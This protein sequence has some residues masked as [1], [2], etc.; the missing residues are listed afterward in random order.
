MTTRRLTIGT[1]AAVALVTA[2]LWTNLVVDSD[3]AAFLPSGGGDRQMMLLNQLRDGIA[4]RLVLIEIRGGAADAL[5]ATSHRVTRSLRASPEFDYASNGGFDVLES[6]LEALMR[7][8]Y[9]LSPGVTEDAFSE[10]SL[11][12]AMI[13]RLDA[14]GTTAGAL[15]KRF[16]TRDPTG[17]TM[18]LVAKAA[19]SSR[20]RNDSGAWFDAQGAAAVIVAQTRAAGSD[21]SGQRS[22][23][24]A[25]DAI[26]RDASV[27]PQTVR[28]SSPGVLAVTSQRI[29]E[30]SATRLSVL[31]TAAILLVLVA[32]Y[33]S[34]RL[35]VLCVLPAVVGLLVAVALVN[36]L[37]GSVHAIT[38]AFG[39]TLLGEAVDYPSYLLTASPDSASASAAP[40]GVGRMFALAVATT[41]CGAISLLFS[42]FDGLVQLGIVTVVGVVV[43]GVLTWYVLPEW[44][45]A[46]RSGP[47]FSKGMQPSWPTWRAMY[48][49]G[50]FAVL[51]AALIVSGRGAT[52]WDDDPAR[53]SPL[54]TEALNRDRDLRSALGAPDARY[55]I[56]VRGDTIDGALR[57]VES[58]GPT[59]DDAVAGGALEDYFLA[60]DALPSKSTQRRRQ[61]ALPTTA[62]LRER[63]AAATRGLPLRAAAFEPFVQDVAQ[64]KASEPMTLATLARTGLGLRADSLVGTDGRGAWIWVPLTLVHRPETLDRIVRAAGDHVSLID[65]RGEAGALIEAFRQRALQATLVGIGVIGLVLAVGLGGLGTA[66]AVLFPALF[67]VAA[68]VGV[69]VSYVGPLS[70]YHLIGSLLVV[71]TGVNYALFT[72]R[73]R[74]CDPSPRAVA[75]TLAVVAGTTSCAFG[76]LALSSVPLLHALGATVCI[77]VAF[78]LV[79]CVGTLMPARLREGAR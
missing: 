17:E 73:A 38:L 26:L 58:L 4:G 78:V 7:Y 70:I 28:Y 39:V 72:L 47:N 75:R 14:L 40:W 68:T 18:R 37:F 71:G 35:V 24:A 16:L 10:P 74:G 9:L 79:A 61:Q 33:R 46:S 44:I 53:M 60:S 30:R 59:L 5:A 20:L 54:P 49:Y 12:A 55:V 69:W 45:P 77:G 32:T 27:E 57:R 65:V 13:R 42:G 2:Y 31:S 3:F 51:L 41:A 50:A 29:V 22:A 6:D 63:I 48:A 43:A 62:V 21:L 1:A 15:E 19:G 23:I 11:R 67:A 56:V 52:L 34:A 36:V 66:A 64:A 25:L 76:A 8:R